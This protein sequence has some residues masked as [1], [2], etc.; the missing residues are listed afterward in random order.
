MDQDEKPAAASEREARFRRYEATGEASIRAELEA[1]SPVDDEV[2]AKRAWLFQKEEGRQNEQRRAMVASAAAAHD[3]ARDARDSAQAA[4]RSA[5]WT[6]IA[7]LAAT[8]GVL[9]NAAIALG[10]LDWLKRG[11]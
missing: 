8:V 4:R 7:A 5:F 11:A 3:A 6:M 9:V 2:F 1:S 10:W